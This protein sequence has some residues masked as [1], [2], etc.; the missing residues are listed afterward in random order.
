MS[1][2]PYGT[3]AQ[4][5]EVDLHHSHKFLS[6]R[7]KWKPARRWLVSFLWS[8]A[9][10]YFP[11]FYPDKFY[12]DSQIEE[13]CQISLLLNHSAKTIQSLTTEQPQHLSAKPGYSSIF[14]QL[15]PSI[16][17][18]S[19][20]WAILLASF[21]QH[22]THYV[23]TGWEFLSVFQPSPKFENLERLTQIHLH[24]PR[25]WMGTRGHCRYQSSGS[26]WSPVKER[27]FTLGP[28]VVAITVNWKKIVAS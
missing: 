23:L 21:S 18:L 14:S 16:Q 13:K 5:K 4:Y 8:K 20:R 28:F 15:S 22:A 12:N 25:R 17:Y 24:S 1:E 9:L 7:R 3:T 27:K 19:T 10:K 11:H 6:R 2:F 26:S